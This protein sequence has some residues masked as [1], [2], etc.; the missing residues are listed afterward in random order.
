MILFYIGMICPVLEFGDGLYDSAQS[1][2]AQTLKTIQ[3]QVAIIITCAL[4]HTHLDSFLFEL[5]NN[6]LSEGISTNYV[7]SIKITTTFIQPTY[8]TNKPSSILDYTVCL[9]IILNF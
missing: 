3:R 6:W 7:C 4:K 2:S 9:R 5:G 8:I 1:Y